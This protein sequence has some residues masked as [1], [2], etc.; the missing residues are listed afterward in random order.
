M[1]YQHLT[2]STTK[3]F[4]ETIIPSEIK[5]IVKVKFESSRTFIDKSGTHHLQ[6][7]PVFAGIYVTRG[8]NVKIYTQHI[9]DK[10]VLLFNL[11][12]SIN[13]IETVPPSSDDHSTPSTVPANATKPTNKSRL[14]FTLAV[15][16]PIIVIVAIAA[17]VLYRCAYKNKSS[18]VATLE[19]KPIK[20]PTT[21]PI[22]KKPT[23]LPIKKKPA[24]LP[25]KKK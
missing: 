1:I 23:P 22:T 20:E 17:F 11:A 14:A 21:S 4:V 13:T 5:S 2:F 8:K 15:V 6:D 24:P 12:K 9:S 3:F 7:E 19:S 25:I 10:P 16:I 18:N